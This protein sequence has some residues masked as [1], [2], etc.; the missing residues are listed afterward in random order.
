MNVSRALGEAVTAI[1]RDRVLG[2]VAR[3]ILVLGSAVAL[4]PA[5]AG[6]LSYLPASRFSLL[7]LVFQDACFTVLAGAVQSR[8]ASPAARAYLVGD[9]A[10]S[11]VSRPP[12]SGPAALR[13]GGASQE[14][15]RASVRL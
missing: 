1:T 13:C 10:T 15:T 3:A 4:S 12:R 11:A 7:F 6:V 9:V 8:A 14:V 2:P 5:G